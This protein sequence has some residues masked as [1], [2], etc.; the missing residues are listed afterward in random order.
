[1]RNAGGAVRAGMARNDRC[2]DR[3]GR[4]FVLTVGA[5]PSYS[6][7]GEFGNAGRDRVNKAEIAGLVARRT[8]IGRSAAGDAVDAVFGAIAETLARGEDVRIVGFG[9][10][11]T[12]SR[13][14]RTGRNPK[15]ARA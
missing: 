13:P 6:L 11:G 3:N 9:T 12:R 15:T 4:R 10:I 8:G 2:R 5:G 1:M 7:S 14:A